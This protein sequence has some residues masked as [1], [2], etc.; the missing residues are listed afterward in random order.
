M[1]SLICSEELLIRVEQ[2]EV[3]RPARLVEV[4][5]PLGPGSEVAGLKYS[6]PLL[7]RCTIRGSARDVAAKEAL[8]AKHEAESQ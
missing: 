5:D 3:R 8:G 2:L 7:A 4:D 6:T 1:I